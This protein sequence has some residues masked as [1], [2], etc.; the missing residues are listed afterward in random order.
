[1]KRFDD[2]YGKRVKDWSMDEWTRFYHD[3]YITLM[4]E[5]DW[6]TGDWEKRLFCGPYLTDEEIVKYV[7]CE[8]SEFIDTFDGPLTRFREDGHVSWKLSEEERTAQR[9]W[10]DENYPWPPV[11]DDAVTRLH[12]MIAEAIETSFN[13][14]LSNEIERM[15]ETDAQN[16]LGGNF[17]SQRKGYCGPVE[18]VNNSREYAYF[19]AKYPSLRNENCDDYWAAAEGYTRFYQQ[20]VDYFASTACAENSVE[21][22]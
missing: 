11:A 8:P 13:S 6:E 15:D 5:H 2:F 9:K 14:P 17:W 22:A 19:V 12:K 16:H 4:L 18:R 7:K 20:Y 10:Y 3:H 21:A 1:M